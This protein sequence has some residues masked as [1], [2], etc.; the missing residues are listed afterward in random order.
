MKKI[1]VAALAAAFVTPLALADVTIYGSIRAD[2]EYDHF[3]DHNGVSPT[4]AG[5]TRIVD[6]SS[7]IGF[8]G[9]DKWDNAGWA[10][11]WQVETGI[12]AAPASAD[13]NGTKPKAFGGG[14]WGG[15]NTFIG[16]T[17]TDFGTFRAGNYDSTYKNTF[18]SSKMSPLFDDFLD[19][20]DFKGNKGTWG[21]LQT[22]LNDNL[23][24][25][26]PVWGGFQVRA[27]IALDGSPSA[28]GSAPIYGIGALYNYGGF[29]AAAVYQYAKNRSFAQLGG[30]STADTTGTTN[31]ATPPVTTYNVTDGAK[32]DGI[33]LAAGYNFDFGLGLGLGWEHISTDNNATVAGLG[34]GT[35]S[36]NNYLVTGNYW[37]N[38]KFELQALYSRANKVYSVDDLTG[39]QYSL[40]SVYYLS[41]QT[42]W[43]TSAVGL[44][45]SGKATGYQFAFQNNSGSLVAKNGQTNFTVLTGFRS[46]F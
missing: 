13:Q 9:V 42:R 46:D 10:T 41:K 14:S 33:E 12:G 6:S 38:P 44:K 39:Q 26:S 34:S 16:F 29:N 43:Y 28:A 22:R 27:N 2:L 3:G 30:I 21:Q 15:R 23:A 4:N 31:T 5:A 35:L 20:T 25:E 17:G 24:Y 18:T 37:F 1:M 36:W 11:I 40:S 45:N 7:R 19:S 32:T 8:K